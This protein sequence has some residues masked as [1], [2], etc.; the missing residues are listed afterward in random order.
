MATAHK[1]LCVRYFWPFV[2][3]Y[4]IEAIKK[5]PPCQFFHKKTLSHPAPLHPVFV[6][7]PFAKWGIDFM[8]RRPTS[9]GGGHIYIII[10]VDYF[11]K[12]AKA[13]PTFLNDGRIVSL[14]V[15]NHIVSI[16]RVP[17]V[18]IIDHGSHFRNQMMV[19]LSMKLIFR[20]EI[21]FSS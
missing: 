11:T 4:C 3:K 7:D 14:F 9:V 19:E 12:W 21:D 18:I 16:L 13:M 8:E 20:H 10:T 6:F 2:F 5:C 15:S 17:Q 1:I